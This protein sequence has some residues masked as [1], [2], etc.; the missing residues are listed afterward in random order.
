[1]LKGFLALFT[2]GIIFNPAVLLGGLTGVASYVFL[3][4]EQLKTV[5][6][7]YHIYLLFFI[8]SAGYVYFFR[9]VLKDNARDTDWK[10]TFSATFKETI[11]MSFSFVCGMLLASFFDFSDFDMKPKEQDYQYSELGSIMS[12]EKQAESLMQNENNQIQKILQSQ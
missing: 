10:A 1:M 11:L 2:T 4:G 6:A 3:D 9:P 5:Y 7:H 8:F 12:L